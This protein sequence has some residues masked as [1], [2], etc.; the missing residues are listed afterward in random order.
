M[1]RRKSEAMYTLRMNRFD[2]Y[3]VVVLRGG[4]VALFLWFGLSQLTDPGSWLSWV[5]QWALEL[6]LIGG[7]GV[8]ILNGIFET[9]LGLSLAA[10]F[11]TR[12]TAV[13]LSL[14]LFLIAF[15]VGYND[16]GVRDVALGLATLSLAFTAPD[17]LTLDARRAALGIDNSP[18]AQ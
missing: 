1:R 18:E 13:L 5:P 9:V 16:I 3:G 2:R 12:A 6:P 15:E 4:L 10:G 8:V 11:Y 7:T 17:A 14:H